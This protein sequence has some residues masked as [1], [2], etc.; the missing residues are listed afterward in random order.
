MKKS[1]DRRLLQGYTLVEVMI[2]VAIM[3]VVAALISPLLTN[4]TSF[5]RLTQARTVIERDA[6]VSMDLMN[7]AIRQAQSSTIILS[8]YPNEPP[9]SEISFTDIKGNL[10][11]F[12]QQ[13]NYLYEKFN[14]TVSMLTKN[15]E[16]V[17]FTFPDS[18]QTGIL[19]VAMTTQ[20]STYLGRSKALELSI[21]EVR[22]MN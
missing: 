2:T 8:S 15:L 7:R 21:E 16:F 18:S 10:V 5:W 9:Y 20:K 6:R 11:S 3:S 17:S 1:G 19:S 22:I 13:G 12:Y 14:T 4:M